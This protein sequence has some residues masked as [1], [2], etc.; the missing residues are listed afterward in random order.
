ME[1]LYAVSHP[2][3]A[4][5]PEVVLDACVSLGLRPDGRL[6]SLNSYENRVY[7]VWLEDEA[8]V[9]LKFYRPGR[10]SRAQIDEE[11]E[12][13]RELAEREI[14]VVAPTHCSELLG[15]VFAAYP[16]RGGRTPNLEDPKALEWIGRFIGR[17]HAVGAISPFRSRP[18]LDETTFGEEPRE[19]LSKNANIPEN[20]RPS[21]TA[22]IDQCLAQVRECYARAGEVRAI[23]LHGDCHAGNVLWTS[24]GPHFVDFDD[25]RMGPAMQDLWMLLSGE[26]AAMARGLRDVLAGY[27][28]F[29]EFDRR[30]LHL[31]EALRSLRLI[32]YS[33]WLA[34]RWDDPAFPAAFPW[35][36]TPRYWQ[37]R[38]L[39]LKEQIALMQEGALTP[40]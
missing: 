7:Q 6:L 26:R 21:W 17:I 32:H 13:A 18:R 29:M 33:A 16:R 36:G 10:W 12:F 19:W 34:R 8:P 14:P 22:A 30:E 38:I 20:L 31:L 25:A 24:D 5:T 15:F 39:E 1:L 11:H 27:E 3:A 9:V 40:S 23:R 2:Y 35:F 28:D 37:D 4:L